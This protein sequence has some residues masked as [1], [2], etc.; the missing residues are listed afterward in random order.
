MDVE[1][2]RD[3]EWIRLLDWTETSLVHPGERNQLAVL[4]E[5]TH[6]KFFINGELAHE[7]D[8]DQLS[9]GAFGLGVDVWDVEGI[10]FEFDNL[11]VYEP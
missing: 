3:N 10:T 2:L 9:G 4:A 6:Y 7:L 5:G 1:L 8:D 11:Q